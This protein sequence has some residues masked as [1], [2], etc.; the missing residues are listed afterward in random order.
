[1]PSQTTK[2]REEKGFSYFY[3][4]AFEKQVN[5]NCVKAKG[6]YPA[7]AQSCKEKQKKESDSLSELCNFVP[8][9][10]FYFDKRKC[11]GLTQTAAFSFFDFARFTE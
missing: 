7:M 9:P 10:E 1:L 6:S 5:A 4:A 8:L 11:S 2:P 3:V